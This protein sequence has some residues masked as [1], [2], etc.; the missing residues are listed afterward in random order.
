M[1]KKTFSHGFTLIELLVV[2]AIIGILASV[3]LAS[4][5]SARSKARDAVRKHDLSQIAIALELYHDKN[6]SYAVSGSG[7]NGTGNGFFSYT[8]TG[9]PKAVSQGLVDDGD[10]GAELVD[11]SGARGSTATSTGYLINITNDHYTLWA[12][13]EDPSSADRATLSNCY[14]N[15]YNGYPP[16]GAPSVQ[17]NYCISN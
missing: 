11:P 9:Y 17:M 10:M 15:K 14:S 12:N 13:L 8:G 6:G 5:N 7:S 1:A 3:I 4:L 16:T 2:I